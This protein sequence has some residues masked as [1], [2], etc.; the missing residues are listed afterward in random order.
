MTSH[1]QLPSGRQVEI[2]GDDV[3][4]SSEVLKVG[5]FR[6]K[7]CDFFTSHAPALQVYVKHVC[8]MPI[9]VY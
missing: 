8:D 3:V 4:A 6:C 5:A 1:V 2:K 9:H 7:S